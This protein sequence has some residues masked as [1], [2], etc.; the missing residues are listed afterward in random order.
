MTNLNNS[1]YVRAREAAIDILHQL[2]PH[3]RPMLMQELQ[4]FVEALA[5]KP[6]KPAFGFEAVKMQLEWKGPSGK[7]MAHVVLTRDQA[8]ELLDMIDANR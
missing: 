3:L 6:R 7:Q 2:S 4:L 1:E 8:G 5:E